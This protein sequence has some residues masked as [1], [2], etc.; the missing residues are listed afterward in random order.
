[1][2]Q[3]NDA[4]HMG[5]QRAR[6]ACSALKI[7]SGFPAKNAKLCAGNLQPMEQKGRWQAYKRVGEGKAGMI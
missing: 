3:S 4:P 1:M 5:S 6:L 2:L 7:Y